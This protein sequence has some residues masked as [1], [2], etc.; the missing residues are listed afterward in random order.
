MLLKPIQLVSQKMSCTEFTKDSLFKLKDYYNEILPTD[1][2][3]INVDSLKE[4]RIKTNLDN[5]D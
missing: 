1:Y 5:F 4:D 2:R 3:R